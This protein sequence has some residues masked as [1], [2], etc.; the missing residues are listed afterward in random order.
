MDVD[1]DAFFWQMVDGK[2]PLPQCAQTLG[3]NITRID[4]DAGVVETDF[5][6]KDEFTNPHGSIQGGFLAAMLDDVM[7]PALVA[8]L[9]AGEFAPTLNLNV[10]FTR[11]AVPGKIS[12]I[13]RIVRR[14]TDVCF[15]S[16]E[17]RQDGKLVA[18]ATATALI[19]TLG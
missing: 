10:S 19:R 16:G 18:T 8:T 13:G 4:P 5:D 14:G 11:P 12:G 17:L 6:A 2:L 1:R 7:G 9:A 3:S 15:L